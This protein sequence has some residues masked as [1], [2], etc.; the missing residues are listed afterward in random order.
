MRAMSLIGPCLVLAVAVPAAGCNTVAGAK[1][2]AQAAGEAVEKGVRRAGQ[3]TGQAVE[4]TGE[5]IEG[6]FK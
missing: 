4:R 2:D 5:A 6:K 3:A 1:K